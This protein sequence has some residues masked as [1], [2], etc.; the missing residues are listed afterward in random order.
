MKLLLTRTTALLSLVLLFSPAM[1]DSKPEP[2]L[3]KIVSY[4]ADVFRVREMMT[5]VAVQ[6]SAGQPKVQAM[7]K[8]A[9][10]DFYIDDLAARLAVP[11]SESLP[12][13][14]ATPCLAFIES[15]DGAA[16]LAVA[17]KL[18]TTKLL[19]EAISKMPQPQQRKTREFFDS[20]CFEK[21]SSFVGSKEARDISQRYGMELAC[22]YIE[23]TDP[24]MANVSKKAHEDCSNL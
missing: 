20:H 12:P 21:V 18:E 5:K 17:K 11:L 14:E 2:S 10:A 22:Y 16:L 8:A 24:K 3:A 19:A 15:D 7:M 4:V 9:F 6:Q 23:R 13:A 1:A